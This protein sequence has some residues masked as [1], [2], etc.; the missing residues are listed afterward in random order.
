MPSDDPVLRRR[1][2]MASLASVAKRVGWIFIVVAVAAFVVGMLTSFDPWGTVVIVAL[3]AC[4][5]T[6]APGIVLGYA[7]RAAEREEQTGS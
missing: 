7:V 3:V 2:Q 6:L 5:L 4:T 1:A